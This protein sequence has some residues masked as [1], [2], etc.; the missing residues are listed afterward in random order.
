MPA[1]KKDRSLFAARLRQ[2]RLYSG[3]T[4]Q[5]VAQSLKLDRSTYAYYETDKSRP[6]YDTLLRIA[7]IYHVST[8]YLLGRVDELVDSRAVVAREPRA[9]YKVRLPG[10]EALSLLP[11]DERAFLVVFRQL[12]AAQ[13]DALFDDLRKLTGET[14]TV[15]TVRKKRED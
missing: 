10:A 5:E 4:Q 7:N 6:D 11:D 14:Y 9:A 8:D 15:H 12:D 3:M 13:R 1:E 2:L